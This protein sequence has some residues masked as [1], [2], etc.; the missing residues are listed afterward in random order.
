MPNV[1]VVGA[2]LR[3]T[4]VTAGGV[5]HRLG[6]I[7]YNVRTLAALL[8]SRYVILPI[9]CVSAD[10]L[11]EIAADLGQFGGKIGFEGLMRVSGP[12]ME[13]E[14]IY[15]ESGQR[16]RV[17]R[18]RPPQIRALPREGL[19]Q[20]VALMVNF[21]DGDELALETLHEIRSD[22]FAGL[23][24]LDL[25]NLVLMQAD[26]RASSMFSEIIAAS[27]EADFVQMNRVEA[28]AVLGL[29]DFEP[30]HIAREIDRIGLQPKRAVVVTLDKDG[31][32]CRITAGRPH[33][34]VIPG[35][36]VQLK[37]PTGCGDIFSASFLNS[38]MDGI[39][40]GESLVAANK[41]AS[42]N[43]LNINVKTKE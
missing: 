14:L 33:H 36:R 23:L 20:T 4:V 39:P 1:V 15:D 5:E 8:G 12:A 32:Y 22:G 25:H 41:A 21:V 42:S 35:E 30:G 7:H 43:G 10:L 24:Y 19:S 3:N 18:H 34:Y 26:L 38:I 6:G 16:E 9:S 37:D 2:Y 17:L 31:V 13:C 11:T 27:N 40:I 28:S 29:D